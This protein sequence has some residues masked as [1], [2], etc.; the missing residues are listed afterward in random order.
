MRYPY[1][2]RPLVEYCLRLPREMRTQPFARKWVMREAMKDTVTEIV[3]VRR[4]KGAIS[5]RTR[6]S[7]RR[8]SKT[9]ATLTRDSLLVDLGCVD[10]SRLRRAIDRAIEGD[11]KVLF[12]VTRTLALET[13]MRVVNDR[14]DDR[15]APAERED[16]ALVPAG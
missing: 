6:W 1:L 5:G 7:L 12:A 4:T 8:E 16:L 15:G 9:V 3:R 10:A 13:W 2:Y 14:W 11:D